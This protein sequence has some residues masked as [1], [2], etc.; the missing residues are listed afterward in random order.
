MGSSD[1]EEGGLAKKLWNKF[2]NQRALALYSPF[3]VSL[4]S[5]TLEPHSFLR[6]ISQDVYFLQAF[7]QA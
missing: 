4:G 6:C 7:A 3:I 5:G 2:K 1:M